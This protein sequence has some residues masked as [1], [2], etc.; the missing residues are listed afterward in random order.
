MHVYRTAFGNMNDI[1]V[2]NFV[3]LQSFLEGKEHLNDF[4]YV[5]YKVLPLVTFNR[6]LFK[7]GVIKIV[8]CLRI[9]S[10]PARLSIALHS[11]PERRHMDLQSTCTVLTS[12]PPPP[13]LTSSAEW[14]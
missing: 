1:F 14:N 9:Y 7:K 12:L 13:T 6:F 4:K 8:L 5:G 10:V 11:P 2:V 3:I